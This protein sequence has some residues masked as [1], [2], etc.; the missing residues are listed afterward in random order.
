VVIMIM[1]EISTLMINMIRIIYFDD[2]VKEGSL[3]INYDGNYK[4]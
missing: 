4:D 3:M 1:T 2:M